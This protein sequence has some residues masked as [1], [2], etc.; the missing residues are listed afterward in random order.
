MTAI[1]W[2]PSLYDSI[3][4]QKRLEIASSK[5]DYMLNVKTVSPK[6]GIQLFYWS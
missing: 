6:V 5:N 1:L 3:K 4:K 2:S